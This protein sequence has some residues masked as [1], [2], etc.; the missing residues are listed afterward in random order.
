MACVIFHR[1][2]AEEQRRE[3]AERTTKRAAKRRKRLRKL[4]LLFSS[5]SSLPLSL[6]S[7]CAF[8]ALLLCAS[9]VKNHTSH[10]THK[11]QVI[12]Q[13]YSYC[14]RPHRHLQD[15]PANRLKPD[16]LWLFLHHSQHSLRDHFQRGFIAFK[17]QLIN[18]LFNSIKIGGSVVMINMS[19]V[20]SKS[21]APASVAAK[22]SSSSMACFLKFE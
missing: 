5:F 21:S 9:A 12:F 20:A 13:A 22:N 17:T 2:G 14:D 4:F 3:G 16:L 19:S 1:R 15:P 11:P 10:A 8:S 6:L 18:R 7:L